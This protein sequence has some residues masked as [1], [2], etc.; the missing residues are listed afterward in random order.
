MSGCLVLLPRGF[1][2]GAVQAS[3]QKSLLPDPRKIMYRSAM[4]RNMTILMWAVGFLSGFNAWAVDLGVI[5]KELPTTGVTGWIH[6]S[7]AERHVYVFTYRNPS[8]FFDYLEMSLV[9]AGADVEKQ[10]EKM[11]RNDQVLLKGSLLDIPAPQPHVL[12]SSIQM[13]TPYV[14]GYPSDPYGH[15][16]R[17]RTT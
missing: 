5:G 9:P 11:N 12:V 6:G 3:S 2:F 8:N 16:S 4:T 10:L 17:S 7:V 15:Q 13:L 14:S 1:C